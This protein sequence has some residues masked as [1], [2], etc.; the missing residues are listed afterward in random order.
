[1]VDYNIYLSKDPYC[2]L[3]EFYYQ[4]GEESSQPK[5]FKYSDFRYKGDKEG[6][7]FFVHLLKN[8][9]PLEIWFIIFEIKFR[10]E[11]IDYIKF[12][13]SPESIRKPTLIYQ[14]NR[15]NNSFGKYYKDDTPYGKMSNQFN[16]IQIFS[17]YNE[18]YKFYPYPMLIHFKEFI[19]K[20]YFYLRQIHEWR[21]HD[22]LAKRSGK[23]LETFFFKG[24]FKRLDVF[25]DLFI[26]IN[27]KIGDFFV[28]IVVNGKFKCCKKHKQLGK[29]YIRDIV[30]FQERYSTAYLKGDSLEEPSDCEIFQDFHNYFYYFKDFIDSCKIKTQL[31]LLDFIENFDESI[32]YWN[33][34]WF[35]K[36][37]PEDDFPLWTMIQELCH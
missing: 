29:I 27:R 19:S 14:S 17:R 21:T 2:K 8:R 10:M 11:K 3:S 4:I 33:K 34:S 22:V 1:M 13:F 26:T 18:G 6:I 5:L 24:N 25:R 16:D 20:W 35:E 37:D 23:S 28:D 32:H 7:Y 15:K 36:E 30:F 31:D 12:L 9:L